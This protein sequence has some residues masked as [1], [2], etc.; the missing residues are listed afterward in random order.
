VL[1]TQ[2]TVAKIMSE[3]GIAGI[4]PRAF[5]VK[6]TITQPQATYPRDLVKRGFTPPRVNM[7]WTSDITYL[8]CDDGLAYKCSIRDEYSGRVVGWAIADHMRDDLVVA[9]LTMAHMAGAE[10]TKGII[11]YT[12]RGSQINS[13][14]VCKQRRVMGLKRSMGKTGSCFDHAP[15]ESYWSVCKHEY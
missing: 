4:S 3:L 12:D 1:V 5:V 6:I 11:F 7:I 10:Q 14:A 13:G 2:K 15:A 9:A 8:H